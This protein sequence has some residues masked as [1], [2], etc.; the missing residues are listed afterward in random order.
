M[1]FGWV[2]AAAAAALLG[3]AGCGAAAEGDPEAAAEAATFFLASN[4]RAEG[5]TTLPSGLQYKVLASGA[6]GGAQPDGNDLV[7][8]EYEGA[9]IDGTVFDS[10]YERGAPAVFSPA[11][12]VPGWTEA[13][14]LMKVGDEWLL[15]LPPDL[16]YGPEGRPPAIPGNSVLV[17][18]LKLLDVAPTP[19]APSG[20]QTAT[21]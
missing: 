6:A 10:S 9:L 21:G 12:V 14:Q 18:R 4:A 15:Y 7:R 5:V 16:A 11:D 20:G 3:A 19:G 2:R 13:L 17:F 8:V 1:R